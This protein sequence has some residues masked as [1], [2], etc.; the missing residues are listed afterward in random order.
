VISQA[1]GH[2]GIDSAKHYLAADE[3]RMQQCCLDFTGIEPMAVW[4]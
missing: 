4:S 2:R 1:L 3:I